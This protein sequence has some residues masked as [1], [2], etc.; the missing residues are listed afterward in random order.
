MDSWCEQIRARL[1]QLEWRLQCW[2]VGYKNVIPNGLFQQRPSW[3]PEHAFA[4]LRHLLS[5]LEQLDQQSS[6]AI[7]LASKLAKQIEVLVLLAKQVKVP[8]LVF[9]PG[10]TRKQ[11]L[12]R[13]MNKKQQLQQQQQALLD[14]YQRLGLLS[15]QNELHYVQEQL[16]QIENMLTRN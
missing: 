10:L 9:T 2:P 11:H 4:E 15:I 1:P 6:K 8:E 12:E 5:I 7:F 16:Q 13:L 3:L 14:S